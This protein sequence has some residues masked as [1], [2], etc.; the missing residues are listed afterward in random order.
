MADRRTQIAE[1]DVHAYA[2]VG[3]LVAALVACKARAGKLSPPGKQPCVTNV[4]YNRQTL[5]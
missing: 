4:V 1:H 5:I 3:A 2:P